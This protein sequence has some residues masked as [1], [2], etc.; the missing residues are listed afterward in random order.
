MTWRG[1]I[2]GKFFRKLTSGGIT[3]EKIFAPIDILWEN[4]SDFRFFKGFSKKGTPPMLSYG[5]NFK[6]FYLHV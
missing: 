3:Q 2:G 4:F 5:E 6:T 1:A